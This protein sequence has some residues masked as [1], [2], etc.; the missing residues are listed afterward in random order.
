MGNLQKLDNPKR[1]QMFPDGDTHLGSLVG[2][3]T[4]AQGGVYTESAG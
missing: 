3:E 2:S 4:Q 1:M